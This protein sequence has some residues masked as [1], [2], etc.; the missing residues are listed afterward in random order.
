MNCDTIE[1][2]DDEYKCNSGKC[3]KKSTTEMYLRS[4]QYPKGVLCDTVQDCPGGDDEEK[5]V[6]DEHKVEFSKFQTLLTVQF[7][8]KN[9]CCGGST[10]NFGQK[11][12]FWLKWE[13]WPKME[14]LTKNGNFG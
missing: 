11:W 5:S 9:V 4:I 14:I 8:R 6:C 10:K 12:K 3:I 7:Y 1:C 13:F 2:S